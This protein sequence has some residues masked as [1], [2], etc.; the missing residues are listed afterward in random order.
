MLD[1]RDDF[2]CRVADAASYSGGRLWVLRWQTAYAKVFR[3]PILA[4]L[5]MLFVPILL[6]GIALQFT[7]NSAILSRGVVLAILWVGLAPLLI[8]NAYNFLLCF[9]D[10]NRGLF[11]DPTT[12]NRLAKDAEQMFNSSRHAIFGIPW[13]LL[14]AISVVVVRFSAAPL[15]VKM[16][17]FFSFFLIFFVS[18]V[19]F[20]GLFVLYRVV[21]LICG[22][23]LNFDFFH[24]DR[25]GGL[26]PL[27]R[28]T[29]IGAAFFSTGSLVLPLAYEMF[30][31]ATEGGQAL[32][33]LVYGVTAFYLL[34]M[35]GGIYLPLR[36]IG[37]TL[38]D[39][40]R[41][42]V[43]DLLRRLEAFHLE[44]DSGGLPSLERFA[45]AWSS[46]A[47]AEQISSVRES[48]V[49]G[50]LIMRH[51]VSLVLPSGVGIVELW[52]LLR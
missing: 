6:S 5:A 32:Y 9:L 50:E 25:L 20:Y 8:Q 43:G 21:H 49:S 27:T 1:E 14:V 44:T 30:R 23:D 48:P 18:A 15:F 31:L 19:G 26:S 16:W 13:G 33:V 39:K 45:Q 2:H 51:L 3:N 17:A 34:I 46:H 11:S 41:E 37:V 36:R 40:K 35:L 22:Q 47:M 42:V 38:T 4:S 29:V 28:L 24:H 10:R 52:S 12:A 7:Y